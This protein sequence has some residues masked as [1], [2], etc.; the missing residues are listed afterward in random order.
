MNVGRLIELLQEADP[1]AEVRV[2]VVIEQGFYDVPTKSAQ[3]GINS[4][5]VQ[6]QENLVVLS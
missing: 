4:V 6:L 5:N 2:R 3:Q 1:S